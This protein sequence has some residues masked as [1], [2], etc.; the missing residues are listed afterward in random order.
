MLR[1]FVALSLIIFP[2]VVHGDDYT[3]VRYLK[4]DGK[5][6]VSSDGNATAQTPFTLASVGKTDDV[7]CHIAI[8]RRRRSV[9]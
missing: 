2:T 7:C 1:I 8:G 3:A 6:E 4:A 9:A 5:V